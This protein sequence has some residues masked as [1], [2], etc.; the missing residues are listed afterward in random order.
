MVCE[1]RKHVAT[2]QRVAPH[3]PVDVWN[4]RRWRHDHC[5]ES[6]DA[7]RP[8]K[9]RSARRQQSADTRS[10][11]EVLPRTR[12]PTT[13]LL[14]MPS[15]ELGPEGRYRCAPTLRPL[16][17][18]SRAPIAAHHRRHSAELCRALPSSGE[19]CRAPLRTTALLKPSHAPE[20]SSELCSVPTAPRKQRGGATPYADAPCSRT[21]GSFIASWNMCRVM[22]PSISNSLCVGL[23]LSLRR[24]ARARGAALQA[25]AERKKNL[26]VSL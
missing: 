8:T 24:R 5:G 26:R 19:L 10:A 14:P 7:C 17:A 9:L 11:L 20:L 12:L 25:R 4:T 3:R 13:Q 6:Y 18:T 1:A 15:L 21:F 22:L 23:N 16:S 2:M